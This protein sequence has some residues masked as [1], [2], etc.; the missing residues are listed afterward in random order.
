MEV[1][2]NTTEISH[3]DPI[4]C[5]NLESEYP[6]YEAVA[7]ATGKGSALLVLF[8]CWGHTCYW[9]YIV[10]FTTKTD[11]LRKVFVDYTTKVVSKDILLFTEGIYEVKV[12]DIDF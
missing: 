4:L 6:E 9:S 8:L 11:G 12:D 5:R 7:P 2:R 1:L 3:C 10:T